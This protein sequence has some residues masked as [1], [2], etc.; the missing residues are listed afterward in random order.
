[1]KKLLAPIIPLT[2]IGLPVNAQQ[3]HQHGQ[4]DGKK[5]T[6]CRTRM[7][8]MMMSQMMELNAELESHGERAL[9]KLSAR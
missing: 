3:E 4:K 8:R 1:M 7:T 5:W 9:S 6:V 2:A